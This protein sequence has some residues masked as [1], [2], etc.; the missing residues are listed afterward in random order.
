VLACLQIDAGAA[1][2]YPGGR[3]RGRVGYYYRRRPLAPALSI[4]LVRS[5]YR[6]HRAQLLCAR[7]SL[8]LRPRHPP[9]DTENPP[10][11]SSSHPRANPQESGVRGVCGQVRFLGSKTAALTSPTP[12]AGRRGFNIVALPRALACKAR[13]S[14]NALSEASRSDLPATVHLTIQA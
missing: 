3:R 8:V 1:P 10:R 7:I 2:A 13:R 12:P 5:C 4:P 14:R 6:R 9:R 11:R